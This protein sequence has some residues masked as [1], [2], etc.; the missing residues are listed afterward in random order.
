MALDPVF[1]NF[2]TPSLTLIPGFN[3]HSS[4]WT[5]GGRGEEACGGGGAQRELMQ[6]LN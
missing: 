3:A 4:P 1:L 6:G 2:Q 5:T